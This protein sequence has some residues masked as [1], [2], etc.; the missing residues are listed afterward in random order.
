[1]P[2]P[3]FYLDLKDFQDYSKRTS[4]VAKKYYWLKFQVGQ[5]PFLFDNLKNV[6]NL[7]KIPVQINTGTS[8]I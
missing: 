8:P 6:L 5:R 3:G 1:M 7:D 2:E 4:Q